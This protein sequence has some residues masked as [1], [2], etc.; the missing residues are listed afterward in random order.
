MEKNAKKKAQTRTTGWE[1]SKVE[2]SA[3]KNGSSNN[4][5]SKEGEQR[6]EDR[7]MHLHCAGVYARNLREA[8]LA[9][10][11]LRRKSLGRVL[12]VKMSWDTL[13]GLVRIQA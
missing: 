6:E 8:A 3:G 1:Y 11:G 4:G 9:N 7:N 2:L 12:S 5:E 10:S 13:A